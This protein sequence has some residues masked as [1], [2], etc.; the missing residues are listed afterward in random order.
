MTGRVTDAY[1]Y[2]LIL[3]PRFLQSLSTPRIPIH[4]VIG[5]LEEVRRLGVLEA[6]HVMKILDLRI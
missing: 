3:P 1:D 5:V 6:V 4:R 2:W